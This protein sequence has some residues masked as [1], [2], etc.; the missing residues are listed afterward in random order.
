MKLKIFALLALS[1]MLLGLAGCGQRAAPTTIATVVQ[2]KPPSA[3]TEVAPEPL[4][5]PCDPPPR[6]CTVFTISQGDRV[7]FA[8]NSD[9]HER[10]STYWV[11]PGGD[12]RYGAIYFGEPDNVQQ[13]FNE[14]GLAYDAN[15]LP[16]APVNSHAGRKPVFGSYTSYPIK[17][18]RECATVEEVIAWV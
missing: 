2:R 8:G 11:D 18:L 14:K 16:E 17:I 3:S 1:A 10:D 9:W 7:F 6:G 12:T 13:G 5:S 4:R 15:G